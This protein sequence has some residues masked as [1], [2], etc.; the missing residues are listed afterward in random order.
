MKKRV[1]YPKTFVKYLWDCYYKRASS[2]L[3]NRICGLEPMCGVYKITDTITGEVYIGQ[4]K[5]IQSRWCSHIKTSLT[6]DLVPLYKAMNRDGLQNFTFEVLVK[7]D[8]ELLNPLERFFIS[9]YNSSVV[10]LNA[11]QG[12]S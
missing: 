3:A 9:Y 4:S 12:I 2:V 7:T 5:N 10:G 11:N 6:D 8:E 1:R